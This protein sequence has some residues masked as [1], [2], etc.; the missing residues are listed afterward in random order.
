MMLESH[1]DESELER[2]EEKNGEEASMPDGR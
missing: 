1:D 2:E